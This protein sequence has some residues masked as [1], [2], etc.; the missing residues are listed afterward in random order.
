VRPPLLPLE[1]AARAELEALLD[2]VT[3]ARA[4]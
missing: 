1:A 2:R 4:A 3:L